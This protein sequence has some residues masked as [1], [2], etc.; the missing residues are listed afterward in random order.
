MSF[1]YYLLIVIGQWTHQ[2]FIQINVNLY[3]CIRKYSLQYFDLQCNIWHMFNF[4]ITG[5]SCWCEHVHCASS[6]PDG[7]TRWR[8]HACLSH[9]KCVKYGFGGS[10]ASRVENGFQRTWWQSGILMWCLGQIST[11]RGIN[12]SWFFNVYVIWL[13]TTSVLHKMHVFITKFYF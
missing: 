9:G 8:R 11:S 12:C 3:T 7:L 4:Y 10:R 5:A 6:F 13:I 1:K 2:S